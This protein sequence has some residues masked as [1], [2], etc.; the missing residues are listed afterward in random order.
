VSVQLPDG[1]SQE[2]TR[3]VVDKLDKVFANEPAID[4]WLV[5][6]G[7]SILDGTTAPN[8]ATAF[9]VFKDWGERHDS[10]L[11]QEAIVARLR[12]EMGQ[13]HEAV[14]FPIVPPAIRGLGSSG[15]FQIQIEDRAGVGREELFQRL[16]EIIQTAQSRPELGPHAD[17]VSCGCPTIVR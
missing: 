13:L 6:G 4:N 11:K 3:A 7:L 5:L 10:K 9:A 16:Q 8:A 15:G 1:A 14:V 2:R 12:Q 17:D